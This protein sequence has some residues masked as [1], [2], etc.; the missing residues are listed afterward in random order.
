[1]NGFIVSLENENYCILESAAG[2]DDKLNGSSPF[3]F[4][5]VLLLLLI[6]S[7]VIAAYLWYHKRPTS[8]AVLH[9]DN[10]VY[11]RTVEEVDADMDPFA[12]APSNSNGIHRGVKLVIDQ[13]QQ[14]KYNPVSAP[15]PT[16]SSTSLSIPTES[17]T[18]PLTSSMVG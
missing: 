15:P 16:T 14:W 5:S 10:P 6:A 9:V 3:S 11:R 2:E 12:D 4:S 18:A 8:F 13:D 1:M 7:T 17:M